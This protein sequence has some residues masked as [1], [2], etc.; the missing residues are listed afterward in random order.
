MTVT[1]DSIK[2]CLLK[3][4]MSFINKKVY[5]FWPLELGN[6]Y[7]FHELMIFKYQKIKS[8]VTVRVVSG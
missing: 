1:V 6:R 5:N 4:C 2:V 3:A 7:I 8:G